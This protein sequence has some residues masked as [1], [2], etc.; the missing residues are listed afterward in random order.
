MQKL[1]LFCLKRKAFILQ[2]LKCVGKIRAALYRKPDKLGHLRAKPIVDAADLGYLRIY[3][4]LPEI[5]LGNIV[6]VRVTY[7]LSGARQNFS[8]QCHCLTVFN[9][10]V[11]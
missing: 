7:L 10:F 4:F 1:G 6:C 5:M 3:F 11:Y 8:V 2:R 9:L